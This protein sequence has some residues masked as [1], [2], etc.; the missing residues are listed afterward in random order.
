MF[1]LLFIV[2][3][4]SST[5]TLGSSLNASNIKEGDDVYFECAV[6]ASPAP[7][8]IT[9]RHNVNISKLNIVLM[10]SYVNLIIKIVTLLLNTLSVTYNPKLIQYREENFHIM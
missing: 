7:Y 3:I 8:K 1:C 2:D 4:P 6:Q 9:W 10:S 5:L